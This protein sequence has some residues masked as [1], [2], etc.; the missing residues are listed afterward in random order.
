MSAEPT[1]IFMAKD[2]ELQHYID[3]SAK[4]RAKLEEIAGQCADCGGTGMVT[5]PL[6]QIVG[7]KELVLPCPGCADIRELL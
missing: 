2:P 5:Q 7:T 3:E 1:A 4:L 6:K